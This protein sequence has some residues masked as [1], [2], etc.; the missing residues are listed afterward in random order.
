MM[1]AA[2]EVALLPRLL[3]G[4]GDRPLTALAS[5][6]ALHGALPDLRR[7][8]PDEIVALVDQAGLRGRGGASFPVAAKMRAVAA[9]RRPKVVVANGSEGEPASKKDRALLRE[10][11]H[12]V[13]DGAAIAARAVGAREAIIALSENDDRGARSVALALRQRRDARLRGEPR[14][15]LFAVPERFISG[16]SSALVNVLSGG[17]AKPTFGPRPSQRGVRKRPTLVQN[18]ETLAHLALIVRNGARWFRQLG[19]PGDPGS[20]LVTLSGAVACP[21]VYEIEHGMPL[22]DLLNTA[23]ITEQLTAVLLGGYFGSWL[24]AAQISELLLA[25]QQLAD[26]GA[27][28]GAGISNAAAYRPAIT[29]HIPPTSAARRRDP[30]ASSAMTWWPDICSRCTISISPS[31]I[32]GPSH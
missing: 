7:S 15:E 21:G 24:P 13:L 10:V 23:G 30:P 27:S 5:H 31:P 6:L 32:R 1:T 28:L 26:H 25:P 11:P 2:T 14:F 29:V 16:Q 12:L 20:T 4:I 8:S 17:P 19:T 9:R 18:V 22:V 3:T